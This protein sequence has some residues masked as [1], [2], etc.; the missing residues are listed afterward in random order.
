VG[1][2]WRRTRGAD[3]AKQ[4][5][6]AMCTYCLRWAPFAALAA[7]AAAA[8]AIPQLRTGIFTNTDDTMTVT[9]AAS[10][11]GWHITETSLNKKRWCIIQGNMGRKMQYH[12]TIF[13]PPAQFPGRHF[14]QLE[15]GICQPPQASNWIQVNIAPRSVSFPYDNGSFFWVLCIT[16][17]VHDAP[18]DKGI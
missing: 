14:G 3:G 16:S 13:R 8:A 6:D 17:S 15:P 5:D 2:R 7:A 1:W 18:E 11:C 9:V 10:D 12:E 4:E